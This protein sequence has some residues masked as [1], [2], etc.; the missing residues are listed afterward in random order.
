MDLRLFLRVLLRF[1]LLIVSGL[2]L[3][4]VLALLAFVRVEFKNGSI[5]VS[6]REQEEWIS[7]STVFVTQAGFPWGRSVVDVA[8]TPEAAEE[9]ERLGLRFADP[10]RFSSLAVLYAHLADSDAV[11]R[12]VTPTGRIENGRLETAPVVSQGASFAEHLPLFKFSAY[13]ASPA[14]SV[15][16]AKRATVAFATFLRRQQI[17]NGIAPEERVVVNVLKEPTKPVLFQARSRTLPIVI[18][19]TVMIA[20]VGLAFVLENLRP[21]IRPVAAAPAAERSLRSSAR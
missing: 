1:R 11:R 4:T 15:A 10:G 17:Q 3:A 8:T 5:D 13:T 6:Y 14:E 7:E 19:L 9:A 20:F 21:R 2:V 18:F 16:L 12:L